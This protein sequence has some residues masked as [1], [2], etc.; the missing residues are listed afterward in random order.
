ML[1]KAS[2]YNVNIRTTVEGTPS[3]SLRSDEP[4]DRR[5]GANRRLPRCHGCDPSLVR[6]P[7]LGGPVRYRT[8]TIWGLRGLIHVDGLSASISTKQARGFQLVL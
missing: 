2:K 7:Q 5:R 4:G 1:T 6:G 3:T 8:V